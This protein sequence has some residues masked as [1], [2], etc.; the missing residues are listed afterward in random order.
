MYKLQKIAAGGILAGALAAVALTGCSNHAIL[1]E[2]S[3]SYSDKEVYNDYFGV[4]INDINEHGNY[5]TRSNYFENF[6]NLNSVNRKYLNRYFYTYDLPDYDKKVSLEEFRKTT[7]IE[8]PTYEMVIGTIDQNTHLT[9]EQKELFK[10]EIFRIHTK[11]PDFDLTIFMYNMEDLDI[12]SIDSPSDFTSKFS[13][14]NDRIIVNTRLA[15]TKE[16]YDKAIISQIGYMFTTAMNVVDDEIL[17]CS[18]SD[19]ALYIGY[20]NYSDKVIELGKTC[21]DGFAAIVSN[22]VIDANVYPDFAEDA[23]ILNMLLSMN[24]MT[25]TDYEKEGYEGLLTRMRLNGNNEMLLHI[26]GLDNPD[27]EST[28][29]SII[30]KV[31]E[32]DIRNLGRNFSE[33]ET[34]DIMKN[35]VI[36]SYENIT[37]PT[38]DIP[39]QRALKKY[40]LIFIEYQFRPQEEKTR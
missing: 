29:C 30:C 28:K 9:S 12:V 32:I 21:K 18:D 13:A 31:V 1:K 15:T 37:N 20:M 39:F 17:Y 38:E 3:Y 19:Y 4:V 33:E 24:D 6:Y 16:A 5:L 2:H 35:I 8:N 11:Y 22:D 7:G 36:A 23:G 14:S 25:L 34:S 10:K 27:D 26:S 40:I